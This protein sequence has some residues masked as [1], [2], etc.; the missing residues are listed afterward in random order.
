MVLSGHADT[1]PRGTPPWTRQPFGGEIEGN[2][3]YGRGANDMKAGL[4]ANLFVAEALAHLGLK[5]RGE[6]LIESVVDEEFG[7]ANGTLAGRLAG[8][9]AEAAI[10]SEPSFLRVCPGQRGGRT[11]H[12]TFRAPG[13]VLTDDRFPSGVVDALGHLLASVREFGKRRRARVRIHELYRQ[14]A[15]PV[16]VAV[17]KISAGGWGTSEPVTVPEVCRVELYWQ[18]MPG[19]TREE[20]DREFM[21]WLTELALS[22]PG[23]FPVIPEVEFPIRWLPGSFTPASH[24][25]VAELVSVTAKVLGQPPAVAGIEGPCDMFIFQQEFGIPA[26][27]WGPRG[28][29]THAA[30]EY[31]EI[32]SAVQAAKAL[33][34]FVCR[35]CGVA[36]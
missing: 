15:D 20:V 22:A 36:R 17:T 4:A 14:A 30:D 27:L 13:G 24:V 18:T 21:E 35:W 31:V 26:V 9:N 3:L 16:P 33:A 1:V 11:V 10:I 2:R 25:L 32:D 6:L 29:N 12:I 28:G 34:L 7:G 5:L 19:E 8:F 23:L